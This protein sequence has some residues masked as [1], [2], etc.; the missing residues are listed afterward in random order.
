L[1][2]RTG[3]EL[4][5]SRGAG[6][7]VPGADGEAIVATVDS[8]ADQL[9]EF[10]GDVS[11]V[12]D[13]QVRNTT[14]SIKLIRRRKS[15]CRTNVETAPTPTAMVGFDIVRRDLECGKNASKKQPGAEVARHEVRVFSLPADARRFSD[16]FFHHRGGVDE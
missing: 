1:E 6:E 16:R 12:L 9:A 2:F 5:F 4:H 13:G 11:L 8:V 14:P 3:L 10:A 15:A 7:L